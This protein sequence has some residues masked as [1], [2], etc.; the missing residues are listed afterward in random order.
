MSPKRRRRLAGFNMIELLVVLAVLGILAAA[1]MPLGESLLVSQKER[2]LRA[3]LIEIRAALDA[4]RQSVDKGRIARATESGYPPNLSTLI[5]GAPDIRPEHRGQMHYFLRRVPR[6]PFADP[7][8]PADRAWAL[9][10]YASPPD[11]PVAGEDVFDV[12]SSSEGLAL[13]GSRYASW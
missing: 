1:V 5:S 2:E 13:D 11:R 8:L 9:R 6:D 3:G 12:Y 7:Q 10:S 4:Y